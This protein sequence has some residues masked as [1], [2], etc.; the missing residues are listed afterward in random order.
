MLYASKYRN[1]K[2]INSGIT[3][4]PVIVLIVDFQLEVLVAR[5]VLVQVQ[6]TALHKSFCKEMQRDFFL[7]FMNVDARKLDRLILKVGGS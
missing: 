4:V 6:S 3:V 7:S 1:I 5:A 2:E